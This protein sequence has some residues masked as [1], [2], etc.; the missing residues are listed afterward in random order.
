[1]TQP[2]RKGWARKRAGV[3]KRDGGICGICGGSGADTADHLIPVVA[4]GDDTYANLRAAHRVCNSKRGA[5]GH[6][7]VTKRMS[8]RDGIPAPAIS[9]RW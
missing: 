8:K 6:R 2:Y 9:A 3:L 4:G 1:M 5:V 7:R